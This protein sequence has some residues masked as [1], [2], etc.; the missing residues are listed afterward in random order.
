[1]PRVL[2]GLTSSK[3]PVDARVCSSV[4]VLR[5]RCSLKGPRRSSVG[6]SKYTTERPR[7]P[8]LQV[9]L[10]AIDESTYPRILSI[11]ISIPLVPSQPNSGHPTVG[12][13][14]ISRCHS[15]QAPRPQT[16]ATPPPFHRLPNY[17]QKMGLIISTTPQTHRPES[18][19]LPDTGHYLEK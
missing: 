14:S 18:S 3:L 1:M 7:P 4:H 5:L 19:V 13:S 2:A 10:S 8:R 12:F 17:L 15:H 9:H 6:N 11:L 16:F